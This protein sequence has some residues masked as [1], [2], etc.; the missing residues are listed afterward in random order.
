MLYV[1]VQK[2]EEKRVWA[3]KTDDKDGDCEKLGIDTENF[4]WYAFTT[5]ELGVLSHSAFAILS[6]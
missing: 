3:I 1:M 4:D 2:G 6:P 5:E